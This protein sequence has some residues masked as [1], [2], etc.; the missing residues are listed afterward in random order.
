MPHSSEKPDWGSEFNRQNTI[1]RARLINIFLAIFAILAIIIIIVILIA[2]PPSQPNLDRDIVD[3]YS[4]TIFILVGIAI[5]Y[6]F[7]RWISIDAASFMF[8][9]FLLTAIT[10][11]DEPIQVANGRTLI[12]FALPIVLASVLFRSWGSFIFAGLSSLIVTILDIQY[13]QKEPNIFA[14]IVFFILALT[15]WLYTRARD[16][17]LRSLIQLNE[18]TRKADEEIYSL[19][20]FSTENPNP[21]MR[22]NFD[23]RLTY[24]NP[25]SQQILDE[26]NCQ[27]GELIPDEY[28]EMVTVCLTR[29]NQMSANIDIKDKVFSLYF[30]PI[31]EANYVNLYGRDETERIRGEKALRESEQRYR[32][33]FNTMLDG[34]S[35]HEIIRDTHGKPVDYRFLEVNPAFEKMTGLSGDIIIGKTVLQVMPDIESRWIDIYGEVALTGKSTRFESYA[36]GLDKYLEIIAFSPGENRFATIYTDITEQKRAEIALLESE[37]RIRKKLNAILSPEGDI[38]M[39]DLAEVLDSQVIQSLMDDF[40]SITHIG[41]GIID[42][43][44]K[45]LVATGWQ[46]VCTKFHRIHPETCNNCIES[47]L[48]LSQDVE[49]GTFKLYRCKNNMWDIAT[50][51]IV[52]GRKLGNLFLGQFLFD[53]E[54]ADFDYF[55]KQAQK[56]GFDEVEYLAALDR[57]PRWSHQTVNAAMSFYAK[58]AG[59]IATLSY[60]NIKL[61]RSITERNNAEDEIHKLNIE[62]EQRVVDRTEQLNNTLSELESFAY[63]VS[64]DL[65][66]PLRAIDGFS[67][68]LTSEYGEKLSGD[69]LHYLERIKAGVKRMDQLISDLLKLSRVTRQEINF[70]QVDLTKIARGV[71]DELGNNQPDRVVQWDILE[72]MKTYGDANLLKVAVENLLLNAWKFTSTRNAAQIQFGCLQQDGDNTYYVRD[73]GVGFDM[74]Y[75]DK[76]F[77]AFQRLHRVTEFPGTGIGLATV[78]RII[79]RHGGKIWAESSVDQ[80]AVFYFTVDERSIR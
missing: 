38:G 15:A 36:K 20:K 73:N 48:Y 13:L 42:L 80:G 78:Q 50:P 24:A 71:R 29:H 27:V 4:S 52:G 64:H 18:K 3:M 40:Y 74:N 69:G 31:V 51:I 59:V 33:L 53:D 56:Y 30:T 16:N 58:L 41:I 61:V 34:F 76:L 37:E 65:R 63:S 8:L 66:A 35:L 75:A 47:D 44:G 17:A 14:F 26:W 55:S 67:Q 21:V 1:L 57:V 62:L 23:G 43:N 54:T 79:H 25:V 60:S 77:G 28:K 49:P 32:L 46:D 39:L 72:G 2:F 19:A 45:V 12:Y 68:A 11:S 70:E 22:I 6:G 10:L 7:K 9:I 5:I